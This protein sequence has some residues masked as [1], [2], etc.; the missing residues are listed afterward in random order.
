MFS[1]IVGL[2]TKSCTRFAD[3]K[4]DAGLVRGVD[5]K[6]DCAG[7]EAATWTGTKACCCLDETAE[8]VRLSWLLKHF[9]YSCCSSP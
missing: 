3:M 1:L 7:D 4:G 2:D 9:A 6:S 8:S 5:I